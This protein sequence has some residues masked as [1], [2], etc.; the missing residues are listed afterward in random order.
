MVGECIAG[1]QDG[2]NEAFEEILDIATDDHF[3][4]SDVVRYLI[5]KLKELQPDVEVVGELWPKLME[6]TSLVTSVLAH[7]Y[8]GTIYS[9]IVRKEGLAKGNIMSP[10]G[11]R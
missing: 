11:I 7:H 2:R 5:S 10:A 6:Q 1:R 9:N 8:S 3:G 4:R